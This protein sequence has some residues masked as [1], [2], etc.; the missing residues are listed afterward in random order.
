MP[1]KLFESV[2]KMPLCK[3]CLNNEAD[4]RNSH[5][6]PKFMG[7]RLFESKPKHGIQIDIRGKQSKIQDIP[8]EHYI[9]CSKCEKRFSRLEHYF[10]LKINSIHNHS[11]E[12]NR[13]KI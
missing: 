3:L 2:E 13:F 5:I 8:K 11:N 1:L 4:K 6:I 9:F 10:S 7:K 12:K